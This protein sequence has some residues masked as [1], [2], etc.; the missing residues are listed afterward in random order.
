MGRARILQTR[1]YLLITIGLVAVH[2]ATGYPPDATFAGH[3]GL[4]GKTLTMNCE[5]VSAVDG[6]SVLDPKALGE[7]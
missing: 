4:L 1:S 7:M 3:P 6:I 2:G 5:R